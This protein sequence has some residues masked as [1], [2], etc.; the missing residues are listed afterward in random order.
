MKQKFNVYGMSCTACSAR[1]E[2]AV[3][4]MNG[5]DKVSVDLFSNTMT[6]ISKEDISEAVIKTVVDAGYKAEV[7]KGGEE[8]EEKKSGFPVKLIVSFICM[9]LIMYISM[10]HMIGLPKIFVSPMWILVSQMILAGIVV[11]LNFKFFTGGYKA[12]FKLHP[13]MDSLVALSATGSYVYGIVAFFRLL[14]ADNSALAHEISHNL[15]FESAAMVLGLISLGKYF[16]SRS[17]EKTRGALKKLYELNPE[18]VNI[19]VDG[20]EKNVPIEDVGVGDTVV[21]RAGD[22]VAFDGRVTKGLGVF[23]ESAGTGESVP[24]E[25][26]LKQKS[27]ISGSLMKSGYLEYEVMRAGEDTTISQIIKLVESASVS[28]API[29]KLA[30]KICL[31]F[32]PG[33]ILIALIS[34]MIWMMIGAG[35]EF[36]V[37]IGLSVLVISCPCAL[38]LATPTAIMVGTG[39]GAKNAI[40]IN[41]AES[42]EILHKAKNIALDKTG[43]ITEG[44]LAVFRKESLH[45][46]FEKVAKSL[47]E[48]SEHPIA[49]AIVENC[50]CD[51]LF[52]V[53]N[54]R[55]HEGMGVSGEI[56]GRIYVAGNRRFIREH[57]K[58]H[59]S[60]LLVN[61]DSGTVIYVARKD[62]VKGEFLGYFILSDTVK[63]S[64]IEAI[65]MLEKEGLNVY[66]LTGDNRH[67]AHKMREIPGVCDV[68]DELLPQEKSKIVGD[69]KEKGVTVMVGDGVNDAPSLALADVGIAIGAGTD[70]AMDS[71]DIVLS[72]SNLINVYK[73]I[74]LSKAVMKNIKENLFWAFF[75]N[76]LGI[77]VAAGVFAGAGFTLNPMIGAAAMSLSSIFVVSNALR[78]NRFKI[79]IKKTEEEKMRKI[80]IDGMMCMHCSG[81]VES[82]L[83]GME[84]VSA[85]VNLEE[86]CAYVKADDSVTNEALKES[87]EAQ[88]YKVVKFE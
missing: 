57:L 1:V 53:M 59:T 80:F 26:S 84:G 4:E 20:E 29:A 86:K 24:V 69:L 8:K 52:E 43:T 16:E 13:N 21:L 72:N 27:V 23:D 37:N 51:E 35:F 73:A 75:Y 6:V 56:D 54:F 65:G 18:T 47:E 49:K 36:A 61:E 67:A 66:V 15:Y 55:Q 34:F 79:K 30:D 39:V 14:G 46:D 31:Y 5:V 40:L 10:G 77:P 42:L 9:I 33:V 41:S 76:V 45:E 64:S 44:K 60:E 7:F 38:G 12:L 19:L 50:S 2:K 22:K 63:K 11:V 88:G 25:K 70:I 81:R 28:K 32:V 58:M 78:L 87:I 3:G 82:T 68:Y 74:V 71:A 85:T 48:K 17:K 62:E 83:N